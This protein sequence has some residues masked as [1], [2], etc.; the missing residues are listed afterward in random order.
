MQEISSHTEG[1]LMVYVYGRLEAMVNRNCITGSSL[2]YGGE[3][4][5]NKCENKI[6]YLKSDEGEVFPIITDWTCRSHIYNSKTLC[7]IDNIK[8][9]I[10]IYPDY[11]VLSLLNETEEQ[12]KL[13]VMACR[14]EI[15]KA[16]GQGYAANP[17]FDRLKK[18]LGDSITK[19][20]F[21]YGVE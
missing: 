9:I 4:C 11:I 6:H 12:S 14:G 2:G 8:D 15:D 5:P 16:L 19:G 17:S 18:L 21:Q 10:N 1:K 3:G 20:H 13:A 7:T